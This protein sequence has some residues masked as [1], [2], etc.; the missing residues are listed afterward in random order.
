MVSLGYFLSSEEFTPKELIT[1]ARWA[2]EAGFSRLWISDHYHPWNH[3][4]GQSGFVW[5]TI[6]AL[7]QATSLPITTA[8]TC[9][10]V[11]THP[12][13]IAQAAATAAVLLEGRF[14]LGVGTG[15]ALNEHIVGDP[16]PGAN[17]RL[18][19]LGE[20]MTV[21]RALFAGGVV[22]HE[23]RHYR[24]EHAELFTRP[25]QPPPIYVSGLGPKSARFAGVVGDGF[26]CTKPDAD[27]VRAFREHGGGDK[28]AQG[29]LKACWAPD[30]ATARKTVHRLWPNSGL[31]GE[32]AQVLPTPEHF[33]QASSLVTE[34]QVAETAVCGPDPERH[35]ERIRDYVDAGYDEVYIAQ[36]GPD[37]RGFFDF[38]AEHVLPRFAKAPATAG[39]R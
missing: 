21:I 25:E 2:E 28:P 3:E 13:V 15:E 39:S 10:T 19:M 35:V 33:E 37:Q 24:V 17:T 7:S 16:W 38:Y 23:G 11:R 14:T 5:S 20:A 27:L 8:V 6:G 22:H 4:Q 12:A 9:P 31:P 34:E 32:L 29:G 30:E 26:I 18:E 36:I 1:Q